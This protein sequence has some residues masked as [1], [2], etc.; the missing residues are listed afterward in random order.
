M[1][2]LEMK[3]SASNESSKLMKLKLLTINFLS[4]FCALTSMAQGNSETTTLLRP[5]NSVFTA[6]AG[7]SHITDTYLSPIKY[8][9]WHVGL[10]YER[11]QAMKFNPENWVMQMRFGLTA[12][13]ATNISG[14]RD[15]WYG[16]L[17]FSWGMMRRWKLMQG[18][19]AGVGGSAALKA[20][21]IYIDR[22]GN[23]P[24][25]AKAALTLNATAY[26][27]WN[28]K[29]G[30][31]PVTLRYQPTL[32]V[33]GAFFAPDYGELYYEIYLGNHSGLAHCAWWGN[34]FN[35]DHTLTADLHF[36]ST[37]L[38]IGYT[39]SIY[40]TKV[41]H[42]VTNI[43]THAAV[44]GVSGEWISINPRKQLSPEARIISATY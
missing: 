44:I 15:M 28:G 4:L 20:G 26:A 25:S 24:A 35:L 22:S 40:S 10:G 43:F 42:I 29:I 16:Q 27:A 8:S 18:F 7:S 13:K 6:E 31:L 9:G 1:S 12:D 38:R 33:I 34:Y 39:G 32:P 21:C 2:R 17:Q 3:S 14:N 36:G 19:S 23:N 41:N 37:S 30:S 5:V 11:N